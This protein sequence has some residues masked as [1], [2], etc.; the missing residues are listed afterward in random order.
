MLTAGHKQAWLQMKTGSFLKHQT[1]IS[2]RIAEFTKNFKRDSRDM[3]K[4]MTDREMWSKA[5][6]GWVRGRG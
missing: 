4:V 3:K 2:Q 6:K 5:R 1:E